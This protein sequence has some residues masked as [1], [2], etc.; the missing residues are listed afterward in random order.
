MQADAHRRHR[1]ESME[2]PR[3]SLFAELLTSE[4][5]AVVKR[6]MIRR[7]PDAQLAEDAVQ[8]VFVAVADSID[9]F[10]RTRGSFEGWLLGFVEYVARATWRRRSRRRSA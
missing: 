3:G 2:T 10:D 9:R 7:R 6:A 4:H 8:D 5:V 1:S